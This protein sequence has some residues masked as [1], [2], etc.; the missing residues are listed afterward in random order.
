MI[1]PLIAAFRDRMAALV[2]RAIDQDAAHAHVAPVGEGD[3]LKA[4]HVAMMAL[5]RRPRQGGG[6]VDGGDGR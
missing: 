5:K 6:C 3:F 1:R 4:G 2:I